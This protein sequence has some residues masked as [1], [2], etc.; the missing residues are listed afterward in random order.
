MNSS[1]VQL[2]DLSSFSMGSIEAMVPMVAAI[3]AAVVGLSLWC[4]GRKTLRAATCVMGGVLGVLIA[5]RFVH[6]LPAGAVGGLSHGTLGLIAGGVLGVVAAIAFFRVVMAGLGAGTFGTAAILIAMVCLGVALPTP[7][8]AQAAPPAPNSVS[9]DSATSKAFDLEAL[10]ASLPEDLRKKLE[11]ALKSEE[12]GGASSSVL[13]SAAGSLN[14]L[15]SAAASRRAAADETWNTMG[16][17]DRATVLSAGLVAGLVGLLL[18]AIAPVR[19]AAFITSLAGSAMWMSAIGWIIHE[20][21]L[22]GA[23]LIDQPAGVLLIAWGVVTLI[24]LK[25]Q[26]A[27]V[28]SNKPTTQPVA[29]ASANP[30][31]I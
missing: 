28:K 14:D 8:I 25:V 10:T 16:E 1:A 11:V 23:E 9:T 17:S 3:I 21:N 13:N 7:D 20:K 19:T 31:P 26:M 24:G 5:G 6:H 27:S 30:R 12:V 15:R 4:V 18:G 29:P 22:P 2:P